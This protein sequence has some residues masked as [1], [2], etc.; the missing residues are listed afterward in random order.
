M[1][2]DKVVLVT[3]GGSGIGRAV[4]LRFAAAGYLVIICGR[5]PEHLEET[6]RKVQEGGS[7]ES[8]CLDV[9]DN[10]AV[11]EMVELILQRFCKI[12]VLVN[13][14]GQAICKSFL[15]TS[16]AEWKHILDVNLH[17]TVNC[18]QAVIPSMMER[19]AGVI[20]NVSSTLG[21]KAIGSMA[22]YC[23]SKFAVIGFT[24]ALS[25]EVDNCK[26]GVYAVC[27]G[28]TDT[29]LH[30]NIVGDEL[31]QHAMRPEEVA[32]LIYS[33]SAGIKYIPSGSDIVIDCEQ[34]APRLGCFSKLVAAIWASCIILASI[35]G[36][37]VKKFS[38]NFPFGKER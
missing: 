24:Q 22:A 33:I 10:T 21:R 20:I 14:A 2:N 12:D 6:K 31:A 15:D 1:I 37:L 32:D 28:A 9:T 34:T 11:R 29:P 4:A 18:C 23:A 27:P 35:I 8:F 7:I 26:V 30:R 25:A 38:V 17:G 19:R 5:S 13:S 36:R 16:S 3:G